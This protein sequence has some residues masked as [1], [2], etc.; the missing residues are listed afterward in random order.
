MFP[1]IL[2]ILF[3]KRRKFFSTIDFWLYST[4]IKKK[5]GEKVTNRSQKQSWELF[6]KN[7]DERQRKPELFYKIIKSYT[8][9]KN[10]D[11]K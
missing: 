5:D 3:P 10:Y 7:G 2:Y 11:S 1:D 8:S 6:G 9:K 4:Y